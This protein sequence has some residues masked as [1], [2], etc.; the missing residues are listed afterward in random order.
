MKSDKADDL[1]WMP[2]RAIHCNI[3]KD[4]E[5][6]AASGIKDMERQIVYVG[7]IQKFRP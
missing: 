7:R 6:F 2:R 1:R 3:V 5:I 4:A